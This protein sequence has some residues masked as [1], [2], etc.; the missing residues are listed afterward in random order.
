MSAG[1]GSAEGRD[2]PAVAA[3]PAGP[4]GAVLEG[5]RTGAVALGC[6]AAALIAT[7][8]AGAL[9]GLLS[10]PPAQRLGEVDAAHVAAINV[11]VFLAVFFPTLALATLAWARWVEKRRPAALGLADP[12]ALARYGRGL[13]GGLGL[14]AATIM[15]AGVFAALSGIGAEETGPVDLSRLAEPPFARFLAITAGLLLVQSACEEIVFRGW[16]LS[17]LAV[18]AGL[19]AA[20]IAS[21]LWFGLFHAD[22]A[23]IN[24]AMGVLIIAGTAT[25]GLAFAR[26]ALAE[27]AVFGAA[28]AHGGYNTAMAL[29]SLAALIVTGEAETPRALMEQVLSSVETEINAPG[30]WTLV[31]GQ[32]TVFGVLA[33]ML[34]RPARVRAAG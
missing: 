5:L 26:W 19:A 8:L 7:V 27:G 2:W 14:G 34:W 25:V 28:G 18:R 30:A 29:P 31:A 17:R 9:A 32:I 1:A 10:P 24:P 6:L 4:G 11:V 16:M 23:L 15:A 13:A 33:W 21:S 22:R 20:V 3:A 12:R